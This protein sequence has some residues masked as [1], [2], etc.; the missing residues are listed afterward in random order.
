MKPVTLISVFASFLTASACFFLLTQ[1][2]SGFWLGLV[3]SV[4]LAM[5]V[6][7]LRQLKRGEV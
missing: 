5:T 3:G 4:N 1:H 6:W 2:V 7:N